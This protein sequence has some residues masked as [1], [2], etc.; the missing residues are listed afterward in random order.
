M[1]EVE[2]GYQAIL[3][4]LQTEAVSRFYRTL[5]E[6]AERGELGEFLAY[7][8]KA[9]LKGFAFSYALHAST[10]SLPEL[11]NEVVG[12]VFSEALEKAQG[13]EG[14][15]LA[16]LKG[17][18]EGFPPRLFT[19]LTS[20]FNTGFQGGSLH[21][22]QAGNARYKRWVRVYPVKRPRPWHQALVGKTIPVDEPFVLPGGP[23]RG[24]RVE[25]PFDWK[26]VP[27]P[28]EWLNSGCAVVYL[29][30]P[31]QKFAIN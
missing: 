22:A 16:V 26:S 21:A 12:T 29:Q 13:F 18:P 23:N 20:F 31:R 1:A 10:L 8:A 6:M 28:G 25:G 30:S 14:G 24:K 27:D 5:H 2:R 19:V 9:E 7:L 17:T 15:I 11:G 3:D 4:R